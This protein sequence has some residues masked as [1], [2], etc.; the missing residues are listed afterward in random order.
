MNSLPP[1]PEAG[2]AHVLHDG[3][4]V[5]ESELHAHAGQCPACDEATDYVDP[6]PDPA[7]AEP[8]EATPATLRRR[9]GR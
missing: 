2:G 1:F 5:L 8:A 4:W 3:K 9:S 7:D 6:E